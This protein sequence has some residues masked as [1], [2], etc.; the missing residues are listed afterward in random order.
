MTQFFRDAGRALLTNGYLIIPIRPGEKRP[1]LSAWQN[2]RLS[3]ADLNSYPD[4]G[5][6][7][8]CGQGAHPVVGIDVDI[9][10]PT[11][12]PAITDWCRRT[13]GWAPE[14]VGA[15]PRTMLVYRAA[16]SGWAKGNSVSFFDPTDP[17]KPSGKRNEQQIEV[18]GL[19]QQF[20]AYHV[21]PDTGQ[22]YEWT[23]LF[24][25]LEYVKA[26]D[27]PVI[28]ETQIESLFMELDRL[29]RATPGL[30][31]VVAPM[32]APLSMSDDDFLLGISTKTGIPVLEARHRLSAIHNAPGVDYDTWLNVGMAFHHEFDGSAEALAAWN[33]WSTLSPKHIAGECERKW[34]SFGK[35]DRPMT[36]RWLIRLTNETNGSTQFCTAETRQDHTDSGNVA[37]LAAITTG[38]LRWVPELKNWLWWDGQGWLRDGHGAVAQKAALQVAERYTLRAKEIEQQVNGSGLDEAER[39][40]LRKVVASLNSW[41]AQCRN[42]G[43]LD[44]MLALAKCDTRFVLPL[45][46]LDCD[47]WLFGVENGVVDLKSGLLR[48][49]S[50]D[51]YVTKRS[52]VRYVPTATAPRWSQ[53]ISEVT[54]E[55]GGLNRPTLAAYLQRALGYCLTGSTAEQ[56]MF[57]AI[58]AG[59]NGKNVLLD[60]LQW[61]MGD[62]CETIAPDALMAT[63]PGADAERATPGARKLAGARMAI[64]SESKEGQRLDVAMVKAHT[65]GGY[66][67]ARGL[68]ENPFKFVVSH[69]LCLMTNHKPALDH[70]DDAIRGRLHLIPFD[71]QWNR[72]GHPDRDPSLP[73]GDKHLPER[74]RAEAEGVLTW[75]VAGARA[76][77]RDGLEPPSEVV[78]MTRNYFQ[79]QDPLGQWLGDFEL[80]DPKHGAQASSLF[81]SF[82][83]WCEL[84][85]FGAL[86]AGSQTSFACKVKAH[87]VE[88]RKTK[89]G[90]FYG[91][92]PKADLF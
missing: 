81:D 55:R 65:G 47:P 87:G 85:E 31:A 18:L 4:H 80:C 90:N 45:A 20:V 83:I 84:G 14:R 91:L 19:G 64:S 52:P 38:N 58:G 60:L 66:M 50:R 59:A 21:H 11:I 63:R 69:K 72:P 9:S 79:D 8:L 82:R 71:N 1:A 29:V 6:G 34:R 17:T 61:I 46:N 23:D 36:M 30:E 7:I 62:Y 35:S 13:L 37:C 3:A 32:S 73:D 39:K 70:M 24:G 54:S 56:K 2:A 26:S 68:H 53:F 33:E 86:A 78:Q 10:H 40:H 25:G 28:N 44:S 48:D 41:S 88:V 5:V 27:L 43:R 89:T 57:I 22:P 12:G 77:A 76:Y 92:R 16:E 67:T 75:L 49:A 51:E 74:L 42:K 15:A